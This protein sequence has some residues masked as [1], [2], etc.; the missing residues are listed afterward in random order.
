MYTVCNKKQEIGMQV[1][2][3]EYFELHKTRGYE[4]TDE[5]KLKNNEN[6]KLIY[7]KVCIKNSTMCPFISP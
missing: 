3:H 2:A 6:R 4:C 1:M 5:K 7:W